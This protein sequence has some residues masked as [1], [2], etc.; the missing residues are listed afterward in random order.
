[1]LLHFRTLLVAALLLPPAAPLAQ[2]AVGPSGHW[3]GAIQAPERKVRLELDLTQK[4]AGD[5]SGTLTNQDEQVKGLPLLMV[6][7]VD[8]SI[9][10]H[11]R[12][13]QRFNGVLSTDGTT[14]SGTFLI[15]TEEGSFTVPF[16]ATRT[17]E[18]RVPAPPRSAPLAKGLEGTWNA[19][20]AVHG[21][22][23]RAVLTMSNHPDGTST[24]TIVSVDEGG[25]QIPI[26]ITQT[27]D[28]LTINL[29]TGG[30]FTGK[31]NAQGTDL[32]G[33]FTEGSLSL[34]MTFRRAA[35]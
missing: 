5:F 19:T 14:M 21:K 34:P 25:L 6:T 27:A 8:K 26:A 23:K 2:T 11:A 15:D 13:D 24:G 12:T 20:L 3:E 28:G 29:V 35:Q 32:V 30:S 9:S 1:M 33:T 16:S 17:G 31:L 7:V 4:G 10:F 18:A 22:Q